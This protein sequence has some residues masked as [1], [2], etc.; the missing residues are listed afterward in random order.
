MP[1]ALLLHSHRGFARGHLNN[2]TL[3][4]P[5]ATRVRAPILT[6]LAWCLR[7][8]GP[9]R[10]I[11]FGKRGMPTSCVCKT[12]VGKNNHRSAV[13][14]FQTRGWNPCLGVLL[15][16]IW[17][18]SG[19]SQTPCG[20]T[21]VAAPDSATSQG[22]SETR[23]AFPDYPVKLE[24]EVLGTKMYVSDRN[25]FCFEDARLK[26]VLEDI[27]NIA[28]L[29]VPHQT[30]VYLIGSKAS[31]VIPQIAF[32]S[33]ISKIPQKAINSIQN[34]IARA[35]WVGK[36]KWRAK[37]LLQAVLSAPHRTD[38]KFACAFNTVLEVIRMCH[39]L[40]H[41]VP[42]LQRTWLHKHGTH[43]SECC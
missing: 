13:K 15:P 18:K 28:A 23:A 22:R 20:G 30:R 43:S 26:K 16:C 29:P 21:L 41:T 25:S 27:D 37:S 3:M 19:S 38:P 34:A 1:L 6:S 42:M 33:H 24:I 39:M 8:L 2:V 4:P 40:P 35:L 17:H 7:I 32:G 5:S 10:P 14:N 9:L 31:K 11:L 12:R 36:P